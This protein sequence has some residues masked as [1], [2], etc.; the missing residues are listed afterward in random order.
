MKSDGFSVSV[1]IV[2]RKAIGGRAYRQLSRK[3]DLAQLRLNI[4]ENL[5]RGS[6]NKV[7]FPAELR[8]CI[9]SLAIDYYALIM[10]N[11]CIN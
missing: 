6:A 9:K 3:H 11:G 1:I 4:S 10:H 7:T 2:T 5:H 8:F